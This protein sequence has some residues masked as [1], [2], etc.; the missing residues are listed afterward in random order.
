MARSSCANTLGGVL[1]RAPTEGA[2]HAR[3][4]MSVE[5]GLGIL[6]GLGLAICALSWRTEAGRRL[7]ILGLGAAALQTG[8]VLSALAMDSQGN[9]GPIP[10]SFGLWGCFLIVLLFQLALIPLGTG[11]LVRRVAERKGWTRRAQA[12]HRV[13]VADGEWAILREHMMDPSLLSMDH[14]TVG[15]LL[16]ETELGAEGIEALFD[17]CR[18]GEDAGWPLSASPP[19]RLLVRAA[20]LARANE[21]ADALDA[22]PA[23]DRE[24]DED[25]DDF[26]EPEE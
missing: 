21:I 5:A 14:E 12:G 15:L 13:G 19:V 16:L 24:L 3:G 2:E 23:A 20:D 26:G 8:L 6:T 7:L 25:F 1:A 18:P 11:L 4:I 9:S 17:P 22:E 10:A